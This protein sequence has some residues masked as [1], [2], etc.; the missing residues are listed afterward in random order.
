MCRGKP[1]PRWRLV[2]SLLQPLINLIHH[3]D[4][5][6]SFVAFATGR[7]IAVTFV[8]LGSGSAGVSRCVLVAFVSLRTAGTYKLSHFHQ[9]P[10]PSHCTSR[11]RVAQRADTRTAL[12]RQR[13]CRLDLPTMPVPVPVPVPVLVPVLALVLLPSSGGNALPTNTPCATGSHRKRSSNAGGACM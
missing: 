12:H 1:P 9:G 11:P 2:S 3:T 4:E 7:T 10:S 13:V 6:V 8:T 5:E